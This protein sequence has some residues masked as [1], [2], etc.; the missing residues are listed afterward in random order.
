MQSSEHEHVHGEAV[1]QRG[2]RARCGPRAAGH[3]PDRGAVRAPGTAG[4]GTATPKLAAAT[5]DGG[6]YTVVSGDSWYAIAARLK[7]NV[8]ALLA[9]NSATVATVIHPG[10]VLCLPAGAAT[11]TTKPA[12][13]TTAAP[14]VTPTPTTSTTVAPTTKGLLRQFPV[15]GL[16][17][18]TDTWGAP[19]SGGRKHQGVDIIAPTGKAVYAADDGT[20]TKQYVDAPGALSG[21]GWRL[22]R[23]DGTY[24]FYGHFSRFPAGLAVGSK[25]KAGQ[26]IGYVGMTG[27]A[28]VPHLHFEVHPGGGAPINPTPSVKALDGCGV[29]SVVTQPVPGAT[30]TTS[31]VTTTTKPVTTTTKPVRRRPSR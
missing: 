26:I 19:R 10:N 31:P 29:T 24:Y 1:P 2:M 25:V 14:V 7:V 16:C 9:A 28:G 11:T 27:N 17:W 8:L 22:T 13:T 15:Q 5:C 30:T 6:T 20:L 21:N 23:A 3:D 18:F 4:A 12:V